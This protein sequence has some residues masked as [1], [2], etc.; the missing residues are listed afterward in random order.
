M[1]TFSKPDFGKEL[2]ITGQ[3]PM[4]KQTVKL[5]TSDLFHRFYSKRDEKSFIKIMH[6]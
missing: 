5:N 3:K 4:K 1:S 2:L 6:Q